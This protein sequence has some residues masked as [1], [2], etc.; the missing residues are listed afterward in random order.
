MENSTLATEVAW[1]AF[2]LAFIFGAVANRSAFCT[3]G[4]VSDIVNIGSWTRMRMWLF[5]IAVAILGAQ[6]LQLAG[7]VDL[8][9]S[10]YV[11]PRF[12][13]LG[14][15]VGG[16]LFGVGMT[17]ASGCGSKTLI[18][19]GGG[20]LKSLIVLVFLGISA[21]MTLKGLFALWRINALESSAVTLSTSQDLPTMIAAA[22]GVSATTLRYLLAAVI[23]LGIIAFC[24][25]S[26]EFRAFDNWFAALVIG[27]VIVGGWYVSG[28]IGYLAEDPNTLEE[29][30]VATN[31]GKLESFSFV[32]PVGYTLE[33]LML[34]SDKSKI[35]TFGIAAV[36]GVIAGSFAYAMVSRNFRVEGF[37]QADDLVN[38]IL[39][40]VLMGFGGV[41]ALGCTIGQGITG[42]STLALGSIMSFF[43]I[44]AGAAATMKYQYWRITRAD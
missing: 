19:I 44:V 31:S 11:A 15:L 25:A 2:G 7:I 21:Y 28:K 5:S 8:G 37:R 18:R 9:K 3:M 40:G 33:L 29:A 43:A 10:I 20:S 26:E 36:C 42:F 17:L 16:F 23:S 22:T 32:A 14:Y 12:P 34:W 1:L 41:S 4:A 39:G 38:H 27:L 13:W 24:L 35:V 30:F 6:S